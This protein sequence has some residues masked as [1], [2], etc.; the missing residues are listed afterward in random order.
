MNSKESESR[1]L[2]SRNWIIEPRRQQDQRMD[3]GT[4]V[5]YEYYQSRQ[6]YGIV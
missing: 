5:R 2:V 6:V 1:F 4:L 3:N